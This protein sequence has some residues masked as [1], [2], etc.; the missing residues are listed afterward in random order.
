MGKI[1]LFHLR[2]LKS[3]LENR[4]NIYERILNRKT[5]DRK[6]LKTFNCNKFF[7]IQSKTEAV[8]ISWGYSLGCSL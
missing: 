8:R 7:E 4:R 5:R 6:S 3:K 1:E 2:K